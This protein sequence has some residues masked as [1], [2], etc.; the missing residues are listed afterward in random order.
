MVL[1]NR[2]REEMGILQR[3]SVWSVFGGR[4]GGKVGEGEGR[5][6]PI[7]GSWSIT[8]PFNSYNIACLQVKVGVLFRA[9]LTRL[10][11]SFMA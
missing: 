3:T 9:N 7:E 8:S 6:D 1:H 4:D 10:H 2:P 11:A 5:E